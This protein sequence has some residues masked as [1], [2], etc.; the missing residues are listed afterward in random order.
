MD[1]GTSLKD[2]VAQAGAVWIKSIALTAVSAKVGAYSIVND[3][4]FNGLAISLVFGLAV[5]TLLTVVMVSL[6][7]YVA[8]LPYYAMA[9]RRWT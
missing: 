7:Y 4:I 2:A 6:S 8:P 5:S 3:P 1:E 9:R